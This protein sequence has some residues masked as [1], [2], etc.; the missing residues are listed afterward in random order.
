MKCNTAIEL[1][2]CKAFLANGKDQRLRWVFAGCVRNIA[3][4]SVLVRG[5]C[6]GSVA[7]GRVSRRRSRE[8]IR[9]RPH[10]SLFGILF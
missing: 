6:V 5:V 3:R 8:V 7:G 10:S 9:E 4:R 2:G 1:S